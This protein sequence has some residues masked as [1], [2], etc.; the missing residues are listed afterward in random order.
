MTPL[1]HQIEG[2]DFLSARRRALL[3]DEPRVGKTGAAIMAADDIL[4]T[5]VLVIT[6]ASGRPVW[7]RAWRD[8]S[9]FRHLPV[10]TVYTAKDSVDA[11]RVIVSWNQL[12]ALQERLTARRWD[13]LI[14]DESHYA[15]S[16]D[17]ARTKALYA[18]G[19]V[20]HSAAVVWCLSG[21]PIPNA[22]NDLH[23]MM[24][25]LCPECLSHD[26]VDYEDFL[27]RY[28]VTHRKRISRWTTID[29]VIGGR[30]LEELH[31]RLDGFWLRRTQAQIGI[32]EP[33]FEV[34]PIHIPESA[35][36]RIDAEVPGGIDILDAAET[37]ETKSLDMS[38]GTL[39]RIT[40]SVKARGVAEMA[41][42]ELD[43]GLDKIVIMAWHIDVLDQLEDALKKYG[44]VRIDGST[45]PKARG[46]AEGNF[47]LPTGPR[48]WLGQITASGEAVDCSAASELIFA[49]YSFTPKDMKQAALRITNVNQRRQPRVRVAALEG[50]LDEAFASI[51]TR[52]IATIKEIF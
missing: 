39:R 44:T 26:V 29:V 18:P 3:A 8:W 50:S 9:I 20:A 7:T 48:V 25:A 47:R 17:A 22:P 2:A 37:G 43:N 42:E 30:N 51:L 34:L 19:G 10:A 24:Y 6:T 14:V 31:K 27:H 12:A 13:A 15:K 23:P 38:L 36:R 28:C 41:A 49:E 4:A 21:T 16:W 11:P 45:S 33:V 52:K 32:T 46:E 1:P 5:N 35:R 40:G